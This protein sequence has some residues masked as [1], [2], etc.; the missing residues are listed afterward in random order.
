MDW[1]GCE[2]KWSWPDLI[3]YPGIYLREPEERGTKI[4]YTLLIPWK[5]VKQSSDYVV[6]NTGLCH[7]PAESMLIPLRDKM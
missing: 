5:H 6:Y 7:I 2:R 1:K 4:K 3:H